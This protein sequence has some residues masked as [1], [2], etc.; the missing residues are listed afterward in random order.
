MVCVIPRIL[1]YHPGILFLT[2]N[3]VRT[4]DPAF[5]SR[6]TVALRYQAL[7]EEARMKIWKDQVGRLKIESTSGEI[8]FDALAKVPLN[9]R[10]IKNASRLAVSLAAENGA[11]LSERLLLDTVGIISL[12]HQNILAGDT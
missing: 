12:G 4:I 1:E 3:R 2:T 8:S 9:G 5:G 11:L 10:Q 7:D 6:I